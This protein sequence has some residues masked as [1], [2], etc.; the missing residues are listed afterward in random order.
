M[1]IQIVKVGIVS[2]HADTNLDGQPIVAFTVEEEGVANLRDITDIVSTAV[3][4]GIGT[5]FVLTYDPNADN[6]V[7]VSPDSVVDSA[8][9]SVSGPVGFSTTVIDQLGDDLDNKI[10]LDAGT[11]A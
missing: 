6:F 4:T 10:D 7:F 9:G 3:G 11:W 1:S 2:D 8:V 5:N